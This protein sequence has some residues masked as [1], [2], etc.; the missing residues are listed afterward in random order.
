MIF[1]TSGADARGF[2]YGVET[3][4][5]PHGASSPSSVI[6]SATTSTFDLGN[7]SWGPTGSDDN[8]IADG[9]ATPSGGSPSTQ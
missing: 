5:H 9:V 7:T 8:S 4:V 2:Y 3:S 6:A 1:L